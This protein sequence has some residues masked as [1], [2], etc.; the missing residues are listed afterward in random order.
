METKNFTLGC[1]YVNSQTLSHIET[2]ALKDNLTVSEYNYITKDVDKAFYYINSDYNGQNYFI[3]P[4]FYNKVFDIPSIQSKVTT[5][6]SVEPI[7]IEMVKFPNPRDSE[8][9]KAVDFM[10][11][12]DS[13]NG[14]IKAY[15]GFGKTWC[16]IRAICNLKAKAMIIVDKDKLRTQWIDSFLEF[17]NLTEDDIGI[18]KGRGSFM[19]AIKKPVV[20]ATVQTLAS[21]VGENYFLDNN[22]YLRAFFN[23]NFETIILDEVHKTST[24]PFFSKA[25]LFFMTKRLYG[26]SATPK[27][28]NENA[29]KILNAY[30]GNRIFIPDDSNRLKPTVYLIVYNSRIPHKTMRWVSFRGNFMYNRYRKKLLEQE[31]YN[32]VVRELINTVK[33]KPETTGLMFTA[34]EIKFLESLS[35]QYEDCGIIHSATGEEEKTKKLIFAT[36]KS[37]TEALSINHLNKL[38]LGTPISG[39][40]TN[41]EQV[42]GRITRD[43]TK[44]DT[45]PEIFDLVDI[46]PYQTAKMAVTRIKEYRRLGLNIKRIIAFDE[47]N[48]MFYTEHEYINILKSYKEKF[49]V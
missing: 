27:K 41:L 39:S 2:I 16:A 17:T 1:L 7:N 44:K 37:V 19:K 48:N 36:Y 45:N 26:L 46:G 14:V 11:S 3:I 21:L 33:A 38:I 32:N 22:E 15:T 13:L 25:S 28:S 4:K 35:E 12:N 30:F 5:T 6:Q 23:E 9:Q 40:G 47:T 29:T 43:H 18:V 31:S 34:H 10:S 49:D 24:T 42:S 20:V 8:Q